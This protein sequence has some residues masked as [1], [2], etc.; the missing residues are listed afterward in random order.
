[1]IKLMNDKCVAQEFFERY[2]DRIEAD[3]EM[4]DYCFPE[5]YDVLT[6]PVINKLIDV[7]NEELSLDKEDRLISHSCSVGDL[8]WYTVF[9]KIKK[10]NIS[11][12]DDLVISHFNCDDR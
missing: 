10:F 4:N 2:R 8:G 5:D 7:I 6:R 3:L 11:E 9:I 1:M 12:I